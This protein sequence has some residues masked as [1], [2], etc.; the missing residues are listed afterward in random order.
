MVELV[1]AHETGSDK[2]AIAGIAYRDRQNGKKTTR[3][4]D[5]K[6]VMTH[7]RALAA[8]LDSIPFPARELL[9]ND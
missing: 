9:P 5:E 8:D 2:A 4:R 1:R 7:P 6:V 3:Q